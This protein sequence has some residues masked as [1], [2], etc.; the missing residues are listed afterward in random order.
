MH[1]HNGLKSLL[2]NR[3]YID[4]TH[5]PFDFISKLLGD[6]NNDA[7]LFADR[8]ISYRANFLIKLEVLANI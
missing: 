7:T 2:T 6:Q 3:Q 1:G 4:Q 5:N 8:K